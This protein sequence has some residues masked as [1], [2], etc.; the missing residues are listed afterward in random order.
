MSEVP[1]KLKFEIYTTD[2]EHSY[3]TR[4]ET[5]MNL[6]QLTFQ[7]QPQL[8]QLSQAVFGVQGM[9][10]RQ[11]APEAWNQLLEI[12]VG[13]VNLLKA[14]YT[15]A[16]FPDTE[17]YLQDVTKFEKL[18]EMLK[19]QNAQQMAA[20]ESAR[21]QMGGMN[22]TVGNGPPG[23]A[24]AGGASANTGGAGADVT[25]PVGPGAQGPVGAASVQAQAQGAGAGPGGQ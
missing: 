4:R 9:Q 18:I 25:G 17:N 22:A 16:D 19:A 1:R 14:A 13:S 2:I 24:Q 11:Q 21:N 6:M 3:E 12:Y 7:A 20:I 8:V 23:A 15:F 10:M 5:I